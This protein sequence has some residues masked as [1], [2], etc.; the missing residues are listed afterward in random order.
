[1][2]KPKNPEDGLHD[3][4]TRPQLGYSRY[5]LLDFIA[6][7]EEMVLMG[8]HGSAYR[9]AHC[10]TNKCTNPHN[11]WRREFHLPE[12]DAH[13]ERIEAECPYCNRI[14]DAKVWTRTVMP[15]TTEAECSKCGK[16]ISILED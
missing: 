14:V 13:R 15:P 9:L 3:P 2:I 10:L 8:D 16:N 12:V 4:S 1:M 11:D 6:Q 5:Q 7:I